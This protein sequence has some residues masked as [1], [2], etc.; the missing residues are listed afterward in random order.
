[1]LSIPKEETEIVFNDFK[2]LNVDY[3]IMGEIISEG[4]S[5]SVVYE[6]YDINKSSKVRI[7]VKRIS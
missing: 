5:I 6:V 7:K 4:S 2:I 1:M 3:L